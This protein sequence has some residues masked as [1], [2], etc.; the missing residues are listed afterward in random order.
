MV[1]KL[2]AI[3]VTTQV[4]CRVA[5]AYCPQSAFTRSYSSN[6][7]SLTLDDFYKAIGKLP[8]STR[9]HFTGFSEPL[10][11]PD[12]YKMIDFCH[13]QA[14]YTKISTTLVTSHDQNIE[15]L[16]SG[17]IDEVTLHLPADDKK[18]AIRITEIYLNNVKLALRSFRKQDRVVIFGE[19][20][21]SQIAPLL[22]GF[23]VYINTP[24]Y[25]SWNSRAGHLQEFDPIDLSKHSR[26]YCSKKKLHQPVLLPNGDV[27]LCCMDWS[28]KHKLG[29]LLEQNWA[30][31]ATS[32]EYQKVVAG[33]AD[34]KKETLCWKCDHARPHPT[35]VERI[36]KQLTFT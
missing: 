22:D 21:D 31:I 35:F 30:E 18:M 32:A 17:Q 10:L 6:K 23:N 24:D 3:E 15:A 20:P 12:F 7:R 8:R 34:S 36:R 19:K 29:N 14:F 5:C 26:I 4:G 1:N 28:L 13:K 25:E 9:I 11:H 27:Y 33:L 16:T 2:S